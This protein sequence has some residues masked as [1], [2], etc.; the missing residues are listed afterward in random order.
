VNIID[1]CTLLDL[2]VSIYIQ[3][4]YDIKKRINEPMK[5]M[6][7]LL[8]FKTENAK[9]AEKYSLC[10][11][12]YYSMHVILHAFGNFLPFASKLRNARNTF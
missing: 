3:F 11:N 6:F 1:C 8:F 9:Y 5:N 10:T 2:V 12:N 7:S 4:K